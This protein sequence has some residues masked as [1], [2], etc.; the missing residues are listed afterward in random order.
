MEIMLISPDF[1][2]YSVVICE[3]LKAMGNSVDWYNDRPSSNSIVKALIR[4]NRNLIGITI[5]RYFNKIMKNIGNKKYNKVIVISGQSFSFSEEMISELKN[6]QSQAEFV[7][8]QWDSLSNFPYIERMQKYFERCYSF[9]RKDVEERSNLLFLPLFYNK[10]Y[11]SIGKKIVDEYQYDISFVGTA[12]PKKYRF[13]RK[14]SKQLEDIY[15]FQFIYFFLPSKLVYIYRKVKNPEYKKAKLSE[16]N[17]KPVSKEEMDKLISC[18]RCILDSAQDNQNGLTIRVIETLGAKR[19][20]ITTN[21]DIANYDFYREENIYI[22]DGKFD[23][24]N[25]FFLQQYKE[26]P[27]DIYEK[28]SINSWVRQLLGEEIK[29]ENEGFSLYGNI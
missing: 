6:N 16:F 20:L 4:I 29:E 24:N 17:F 13:I 7:L 12:H 19:K 26:L 25:T 1:F 2:D 10:R 27:K 28:Y 8:Y 11:E 5:K 14:M 9:D 15:R 18:S 21:K 3:E 23:F 22:Y